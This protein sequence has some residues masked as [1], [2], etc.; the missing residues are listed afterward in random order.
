MINNDPE[1]HNNDPETSLNE[2]T[3]KENWY[4]KMCPI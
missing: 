1:T 4:L 2:N 3:V